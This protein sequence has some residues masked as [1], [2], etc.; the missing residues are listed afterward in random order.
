MVTPSQ[1]IQKVDACCLRRSSHIA[2]ERKGSR[3]DQARA[4]LVVPIGVI[5]AVAIV[6]VIVAVLTSAHRAD[7]VSFNS[8]QQL[9]RQAIADHGERALHVLEG[10][11]ATPRATLNDPRQLRSAMGR[12]SASGSGC[13]P[14][15]TTTLR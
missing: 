5:V 7:E 4:S 6:C 2:G 9:I 12:R 14:L 10:T 3:W 15:S 13:K 11:A 1:Y 8:E